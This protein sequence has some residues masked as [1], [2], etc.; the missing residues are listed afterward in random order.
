MRQVPNDREKK[1]YNISKGMY[2]PFKDLVAM[3]LETIIELQLVFTSTHFIKFIKERTTA[4]NQQLLHK[5]TRYNYSSCDYDSWPATASTNNS[6]SLQYC[7][8]N[9]MILLYY[10]FYFIPG[11][12]HHNSVQCCT[13]QWKVKPNFL[14]RLQQQPRYL[15]G[16]GLKSHL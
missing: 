12:V 8:F 5:R 10:P 11:V 9:N 7:Y 1:L 4:A 6:P 13:L 14:A 3:C 2:Q 16:P 15:Q